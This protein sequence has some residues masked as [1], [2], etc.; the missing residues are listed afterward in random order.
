MPKKANGSEQEIKEHKTEELSLTKIEQEVKSEREIFRKKFAD[1][2]RSDPPFIWV[3]GTIL[4]EILEDIFLA[5]PANIKK[6]RIIKKWDALSPF[7]EGDEFYQKSIVEIIAE[8]GLEAEKT[9]DPIILIMQAPDQWYEHK[10]FVDIF[11]AAIERGLAVVMYGGYGELPKGLNDHAIVLDYVLE[12]SEKSFKRV[13]LSIAKSEIHGHKAKWISDNIN[14]VKDI[15]KGCSSIEQEHGLSHAVV[16]SETCEEFINDLLNFKKE[17]LIKNGLIPIDLEECPR[18]KDVGGMDKLKEFILNTKKIIENYD[19][20]REQHNLPLPKGIMLFGIPG[21]G[22]S[23]VSKAIAKEFNW[24][25]V[26]LDPSQIFHRYVG[27]SEQNL[28]NILK[29]V[30]LMSP[31]VL[32]IDEIDKVFA[33]VQSSNVSD[34]GTTAKVFGMFLTWMQEIKKKVFV[35][36]TANS[37]SNLPA[38]LKRRER[39]DQ[40]FFVDLPSL[41]EAREIVNIHLDKYK[42]DKSNLDINTLAQKAISKKLTGA[43]IESAIKDAVIKHCVCILN[44]QESKLTNEVLINSIMETKGIADDAEIKILKKDAEKI[45]IP[46]SSIVKEDLTA[47]EE[48]SSKDLK[49][50]Q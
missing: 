29:R 24:P 3:R 43:E 48:I 30:E 37:V 5:I 34:A 1:F 22:K 35:I 15:L 17:I 31:I 21:T 23:Y 50:L 16:V 40:I 4:R 20:V 19:I 32:F 38:P 49:D 8:L 18:L 12:Y 6:T 45:A 28:K 44:G 39:F 11:T 47:S 9:G 7:R 26:I 36:A 14:I 13:V 27:A 10:E 33:G 46:A 2:L 25:L 42:V 41:T